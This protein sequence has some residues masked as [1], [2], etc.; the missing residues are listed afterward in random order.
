MPQVQII[1]RRRLKYVRLSVRDAATVR[2]TVPHAYTQTEIDRL[3][4]AKRQWIVGK[5]MLMRERDERRESSPDLYLGKPLSIIAD[6]DLRI[7][8][9]YDATTGT[10]YVR[11]LPSISIKSELHR[12]YRSQAKKLL[13]GRVAALAARAGFHY[14]RVSIRG[15]RSRFGSCSSKGNISLNWKLMRCPLPIIDYVIF[16]EL[17]HLKEMNHSRK[18]WAIVA[19]LCPSYKEGKQWLKDHDHVLGE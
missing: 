17:A 18:F 2:L 1:R 11:A 8:H 6:P 10:V 3:L 16:H 15:Q 19:E 13:P 4:A 12:W 7:P 5:L 9:R 14:R